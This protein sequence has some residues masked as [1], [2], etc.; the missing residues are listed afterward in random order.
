[1]GGI[2]PQVVP[3]GGNGKSQAVMRQA[4]SFFPVGVG[5]LQFVPEQV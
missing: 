2:D 1:M 3:V 4:S 5:S